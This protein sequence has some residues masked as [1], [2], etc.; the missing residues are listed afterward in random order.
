M[1]LTV[2]DPVRVRRVVSWQVLDGDMRRDHN[3]YVGTLKICEFGF[4]GF[5]DGI[6]TFR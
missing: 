3:A 2:T 4:P 5:R 6:D 1:P